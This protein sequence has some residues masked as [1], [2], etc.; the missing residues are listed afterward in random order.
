MDILSELFIH[1]LHSRVLEGV[2]LW[3]YT[4]RCN[5]HYADD[6]LIL[7]TSGFEDLRIIK[8]ILFFQGMT[9]LEV[10]FS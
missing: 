3:D 1:T 8:L 7:T 9:G 6:L 10:N 2:P 5:I 4:S